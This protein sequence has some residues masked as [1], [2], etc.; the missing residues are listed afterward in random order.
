L[1][2][3]IAQKMPYSPERAIITG[4]FAGYVFPGKNVLS[5]SFDMVFMGEDFSSLRN[6]AEMSGK[7]KFI[8]PGR[9][10]E[11]CQAVN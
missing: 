7:S 8:T 9:K 2:A 5:G 3:A 1:F 6:L 10:S 4:E 11:F